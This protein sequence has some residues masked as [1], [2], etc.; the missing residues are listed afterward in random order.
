MYHSMAGHSYMSAEV[1]SLPGVLGVRH[2]QL[3]SGQ[4]GYLQLQG[5]CWKLGCSSPGLGF[6]TAVVCGVWIGTPHTQHMTLRSVYHAL[7]AIA[8]V[9]AQPS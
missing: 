9:V 8:L 6:E 2:L 3:Q 1:T 5:S 7:V 4:S